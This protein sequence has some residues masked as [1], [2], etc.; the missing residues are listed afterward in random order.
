MSVEVAPERRTVTVGAI[1]AAPRLG[2]IAAAFRRAHP[3]IAIV[4]RP[5]DFVDDARVVGD[6]EGDAAFLLPAYRVADDLLIEDV[7][8]LPVYVYPTIAA[9]AIRRIPTIDV[10]PFT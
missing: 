8:P 2:E 1:P 4:W 3:D 9:D 6:G 5:L 10:P 7:F